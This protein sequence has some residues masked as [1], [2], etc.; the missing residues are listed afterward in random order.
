MRRL[1]GIG[2]TPQVI[3]ADGID[4][5]KVA[6]DFTLAGHVEDVVGV[7]PGRDRT[8]PALALMAH[9]DSVPGS[10]G[11]SDDAA[12]VS[13]ALEV[14][15]A[16][17]ARGVPAR[18]V[19]VLLTDGEEAGLL[20]ADVF[21]RD[22]MAKRV[23]FIFNLEARGSTGRAQ[24]FQTGENNAG[25]VRLM[26]AKSRRP[27]A[28]SLA[29]LV[30]KFVPSDTDF[31]VSRRAGVAGLNYAFI[32]HQFDYHSPS[33]TPARQDPGSLQDLGDQV[34]GP[35]AAIAFSPTLPAAGPD[36]VF[37]Q[38][39][40]G[41]TLAY[42]PWAGWLILAAAAALIAWGIARARAKEPFPWLDLP[43]GA[44][45][46][47]FAVLTGAAILHFARKATGVAMGYYEQR[48]LL[49]QA[50]LWEAALFLL[51]LGAVLFAASEL[52]R[53]KR[54][55]A[56][57]PLVVGVACCA[58]GSL[59]K[60][61]LAL[62]ALG[63]VV[64]LLAYGRP[65]SRAGGWSG[66]LLLGLVL[67][68]A[69]QAFAPPAAFVLAW[70]LAWAALAAAATAAASHKG[71]GPIL[72]TALFAA[73]GLAMAASFAHALYLSLD[74]PEALALSLLMAALVVWPLAQTEEGAPPARLLGPALILAGLA[75]TVAVRLS[76]P[77]DGRHPQL[78]NVAYEID[79]DA[80]KAWRV[81]FGPDRPP[82]VDAVLSAGGGKIG[83]KP[84]G[85]RGLRSPAA[86]A[87]YVETPAPQITLS[88]AADGRLVLHVVPPPGARV[89]DLKLRPDTAA[90]L[91]AAG[92]APLHAPLI[93][94]FDNVLRW[95]AA[96][97][98]FDLTIQPGGPGKL[99]VGYS[100]TLE[101]WPAGVTPLPPRPKTLMAFDMSDS[102]V[103]EGTRSFV[104]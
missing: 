72:L 88:K 47:L 37:S 5:P 33:S 49:A 32:G 34:L 96:Q 95:S 39:P 30:F 103:I 29:G 82:W 85:R 58:F 56:L 22:P 3:A 101:Q 14:V 12:G 64:G 21:F 4:A 104:W 46:A 23:G 92:G 87:A 84:S 20:G 41:L 40:G 45:A 43:R 57:L 81:S 93:P 44:G 65:A 15:R 28:S 16:I 80:H 54:K 94:G 89:V 31:T 60:V 1:A 19:I 48:F 91:V 53:G 25:T 2:L 9:Y 13:S 18:D 74:L 27:S 100:A 36:L 38:T 55:A 97:P 102:T 10:T 73:V 86:P 90:T 52:S 11:A 70:P 69:L 99:T 17:K 71:T 7:L 98:S 75:V 61:G 78:T 83:S 51:G 67:A 77:Y 50:P 63:A 35:A 76:H 62:G 68:I 24:M 8:L 26:M 42:P 79:Q 59:D 6:R 66:V